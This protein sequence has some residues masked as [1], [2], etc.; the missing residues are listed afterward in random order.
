MEHRA[1]SRP[2]SSQGTAKSSDIE[3]IRSRMA[4]ACRWRC[5]KCQL[6]LAETGPD[7]F[8][9][10]YKDLQLAFHGRGMLVVKCRRCGE[11]N[12]ITVGEWAAT[13]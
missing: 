9:I 3:R 12:S 7:T 13:A 10:V 8:D 5:K 1:Q 6:R 11:L 4:Q 2:P